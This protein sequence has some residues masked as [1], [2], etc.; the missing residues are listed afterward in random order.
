MPPRD[1]SGREVVK[2][3]TKNRFFIVDR[4]GSHVKLR[5]EHPTNDEDVRVVSVPMH[6]RIDTG[7]LRSIAEQ[8]GARDFDAFC[9]WIGRH[10]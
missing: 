6:G 9:A 8:S 10:S 7:T 2:A 1:F 3:L 4:T 5:Y